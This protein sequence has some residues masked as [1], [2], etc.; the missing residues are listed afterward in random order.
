M[1]AETGRKLADNVTLILAARLVS[2]L[3][4]PIALLVFVWVGTSVNSLNLSGV[5]QEQRLETLEREVRGMKEERNSYNI[6]IASS[7]AGMAVRLGEIE[8]NGAVLTQQT[9]ELDRR[10][11]ELARYLQSRLGINP[12]K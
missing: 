9:K 10:A 3:L 1:N 5:K 12:P 7:L 2:V 6:A 11:E 4:A 8:R